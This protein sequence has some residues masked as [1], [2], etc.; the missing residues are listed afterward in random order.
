M[1]TR[2][3]FRCPKCGQIIEQVGTLGVIERPVCPTDGTSMA[4][5][6]GNY[7]GSDIFINYG[8]RESRYT[9]EEEANIAKFQ[10]TNL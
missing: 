10:F 2:R 8:Y 1:T 6:F 5:Y 9:S 4:S 7:Q 3:S